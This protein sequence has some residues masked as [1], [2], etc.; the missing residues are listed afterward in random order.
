MALVTTELSTCCEKLGSCLPTFLVLTFASEIPTQKK[1]CVPFPCSFPPEVVGEWN[2]ESAAYLGDWEP[3][4]VF[5]VLAISTV[6]RSQAL[7]A[8]TDKHS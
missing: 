8:F 3:A 4:W 1:P 6:L 2:K 5:G 7:T